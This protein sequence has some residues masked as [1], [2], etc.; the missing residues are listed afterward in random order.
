MQERETV[1]EYAASTVAET[2]VLSFAREADL[3]SEAV[4]DLFYQYVNLLEEQGETDHETVFVDGTKL[5]SCAGRY[6]FCWKGSVEKSLNKVKE[7]VEAAVGIKSL[8]TL[9]NHLEES[10]RN[11]SFV[12]GKGRQKSQEQRRWEILDELC[13]K[14][15]SY[16]RSLE[17]MQKIQSGHDEEHCL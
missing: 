12:H 9:Q 3:A 13:Q 5:E 1:A 11:I 8:Q 15:E 17:I 7:K 6:T 14:W 4:E 16:E 10:R 2:V